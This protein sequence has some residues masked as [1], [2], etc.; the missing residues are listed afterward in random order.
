MGS[1]STPDN[2]AKPAHVLYSPRECLG[3]VKARV[4]GDP[5]RRLASTSYVERSNLAVRMLNSRYTRLTNSYS[6]RNEYHKAAIALT[7]LS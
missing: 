3:V 5:D 2:T 7:F 6:K 4:Q 1:F